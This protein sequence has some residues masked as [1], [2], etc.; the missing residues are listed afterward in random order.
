MKNKSNKKG[1][2]LVSLIIVIITLIMISGII[3]YI[4]YDM[5]SE[6]KEVTFAKDIQTLIDAAE[7]YYAVNGSI[8]T[9]EGGM[10]LTAAEYIE[11]IKNINGNEIS[12]ILEEEISTNGDNEATFFE[13]DISKLGIKEMKLGIKENENDIYLISNNSHIVY[14]Y[15]G[16]EVKDNVYFSSSQLT[17]KN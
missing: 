2:S 3:T 16:Y 17:N 8:P 9:L 11:N 6:S 4:G 12:N 10:E 14:Y 13:I 7:E 5:V 1:I 15:Q